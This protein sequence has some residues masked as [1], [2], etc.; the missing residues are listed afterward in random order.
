MLEPPEPLSSTYW[1]ELR[2]FLEVATARSFKGPVRTSERAMPKSGR[3][4]RRLEE[5]LGVPLI[6]EAYGRGIKLTPGGERL[7]RELRPID[8][9][10]AKLLGNF[11]SAPDCV[12]A[13]G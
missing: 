13:L 12:I 2:V 5:E 6:A 3:A 10:F 7:A 9:Q 11:S 8:R 1:A 4:V